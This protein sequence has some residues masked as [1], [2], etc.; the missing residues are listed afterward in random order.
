M[1]RAELYGDGFFETIKIE[2]CKPQLWDLHLKRITFALQALRFENESF[3]LSNFSE[4]I[5]SEILNS[6]LQTGR[7]RISFFRT[8][9]GYYTPTNHSFNYNIKIESYNEICKPL[10]IGIYPDGVKARSTF[11]S[12]KTT[13]AQLYVLAGLYAKEQ[14]WDDIIIMNQYDRV[15]EGLSSN[16]F[17]VKDNQIITPPLS[18][19][20]VDGIMRSFIMKN[21]GSEY[22][23]IEKEISLNDMDNCTE[24]WFSNALQGLRTTTK[25]KERILD[26]RIGR[27]LQRKIK[28]ALRQS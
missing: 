16:L 24:I 9:Q 26:D 17:I 4:H 8:G 22:S 7:C 19:L 23:I 18:E 6:G 28:N 11:S 15:C 21:F 20:C 12:I 2:D 25:Y 5:K 13:S 10:E 27:E 1:N 14:N 3:E